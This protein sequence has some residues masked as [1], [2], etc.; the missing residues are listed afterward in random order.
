MLF[1][2]DGVPAL[3]YHLLVVPLIFITN[4][5]GDGVV[6]AGG[7]FTDNSAAI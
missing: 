2:D 5:T 7:T 4:P 1:V 6:I 3:K